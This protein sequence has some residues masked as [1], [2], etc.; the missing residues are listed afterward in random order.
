MHSATPG[1]VTEPAEQR[2]HSFDPASE[3]LPSG[4]FWQLVLFTSKVLA[5]HA[6][7]TPA[8]KGAI[9]PGWQATH[10]DD[11]SGAEL[12]AGHGIHSVAPCLEK[13]PAGHLTQVVLFTS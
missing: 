6:L 2:L 10:S 5:G 11:P 8:P 12:P 13:L 7:Q 3:E 9:Y 4:H 1:R